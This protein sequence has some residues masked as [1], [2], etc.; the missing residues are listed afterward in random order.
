MKGIEFDTSKTSF[1]A[2]LRDQQIKAMQVIWNNSEGVNSRI[3]Y[4]KVNQVLKVETISRASVINFI[5]AVREMGVIS[6]EEKTGKGG[7]HWVY[8]PTIGE[9]GFKKYIVEKLLASF[10]ALR[11]QKMGN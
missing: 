11:A 4:Q 5:Q 10:V 2:V 6:G 1:N 9:A 7:Y 3:M 8:Y